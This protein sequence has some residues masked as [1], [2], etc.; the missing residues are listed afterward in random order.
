MAYSILDTP[1][2]LYQF[3]H[4]EAY[5]IWLPIWY[6]E[7]YIPC[8]FCDALIKSENY[9]QLQKLQEHF[10]KIIVLV[11]PR[12]LDWRGGDLKHRTDSECK[13]IEEKL[14]KLRAE[15]KISQQV[16]K[17]EI[18]KLKTWTPSFTDKNF[19]ECTASYT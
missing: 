1:I 16:F 8:E 13:E 14:K 11:D 10:P 19:T 15:G 7:S 2:D 3:K 12:P 17:I 18:L 9:K 4:G 6:V 5:C